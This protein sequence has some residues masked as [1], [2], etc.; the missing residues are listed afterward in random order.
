M[1]C[2]ILVIHDDILTRT[3]HTHPRSIGLGLKVCQPAPDEIPKQLKMQMQNLT[4]RAYVHQVC[5]LLSVIH[6]MCE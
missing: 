1:T 3:H 4:V 6:V 2:D 5:R